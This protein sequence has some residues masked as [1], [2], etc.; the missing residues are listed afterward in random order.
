MLILI[1]QYIVF[2]SAHENRDA[3][4]FQAVFYVA[5]MIRPKEMWYN[6]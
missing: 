1:S 2:P 4:F 6:M 3:Y 5:F